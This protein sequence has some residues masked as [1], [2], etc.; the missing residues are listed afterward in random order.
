MIQVYLIAAYKHENEKLIFILTII[1]DT[2]PRSQFHN[3]VK[4]NLS[5]FIR[6]NPITMTQIVQV[7]P[8]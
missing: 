4:N 7:G 3:T 5:D 8:G 1:Y 2:D 6:N